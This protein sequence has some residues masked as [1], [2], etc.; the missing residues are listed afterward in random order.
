MNAADAR[1]LSEDQELKIIL[2]E[3]KKTILSGGGFIYVRYDKSEKTKAA[4]I[5]LGYKLES[6]KR[7]GVERLKNL[8]ISWTS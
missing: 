3:I 2:D 1:K 6:H 5:D 7:Y 8:K 4:L